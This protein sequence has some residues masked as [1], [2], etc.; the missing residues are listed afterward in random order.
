MKSRLV[1]TLSAILV[2][3]LSA[4][5]PP[6]GA[7]GKSGAGGMGGS[8]QFIFLG[9]MILV[10]WLFFIRPQAKRAK[11]QKLFIENLGKGEKVVT[12]SGIH[13]TIN[14]VNEDGTLMIEVSPGSY[15]KMEKSAISMEMT[16]ALNKAVTTDKKI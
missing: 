4:C 14:K 1:Y 8:I 10:F 9:M 6:P 11:N 2:L 15:L 13:G 16:A 7:D 12:I 3:S 5:T